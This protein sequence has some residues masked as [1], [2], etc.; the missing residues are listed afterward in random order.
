MHV[1]I[2]RYALSLLIHTFPFSFWIGLVIWCTDLGES[3]LVFLVFVAH[4]LALVCCLPPSV[5]QWLSKYRIFVIS[6]LPSSKPW[7]V[8]KLNVAQEGISSA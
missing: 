1:S 5:R 2:F 8:I 3:T 7:H 4:F 6:L